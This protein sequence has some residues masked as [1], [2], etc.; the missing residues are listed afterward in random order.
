MTQP[1]L[2]QRIKKAMDAN[3]AGFRALL[4]DALGAIRVSR[5]GY[6]LPEGGTVVFNVSS[7]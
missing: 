6:E 2:L 5:W 7:G 1:D 4:T 3:H